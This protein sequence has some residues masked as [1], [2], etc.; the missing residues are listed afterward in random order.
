MP[1]LLLLSA[2][3]LLAAPEVA[4]RDDF[5][6][7]DAWAGNNAKA[8]ADIAGRDGQL[9]LTDPPG[10]EVTWGTSIARNIGRIDLGRFPW[11]VVSVPAMT[12]TFQVKMVNLTTKEKSEPLGQLTAPGLLLV[13]IPEATKWQGE[14]ELSLWCYVQGT[15]KSVTVDWVKVV[16]ALTAEEQQSRPRAV[17]LRE[18]LPHHGLTALASRNAWRPLE[19]FRH[20]AIWLSERVVYRDTATGNTV[21]RMTVDPG[22]DKVVYYDLPEWNADGSL[23]MFET[24]RGL[25]RTWVMH[26][27]GTG[28]RPLFGDA[29]ATYGAGYWSVQNPDVWYAQLRDESGTAVVAYDVRTGLAKPVVRTAR[30]DLSLMPPHPGEQHF[31]LAR[32]AGGDRPDCEVVILGV[33]GSE[34]VV[35]IGGRFHRLR[36]AKSPD[37]RVFYNRDDPRTQWVIL[38]DGSGRTEIPDPGSH[39]DWTWNGQY[40]TYFGAGG[41]YRNTADGQHRELVFAG[42]GGHGGPS[43]D[44][45]WFVGDQYGGAPFPFSIV[46]SPL[47]PGSVASQL[48]SHGSRPMSHDAPS[49]AH[50]DHHSTHP[51]PSFSPDG[52]KAVFSSY[53][54]RAYVDIHVA[55]ARYPDPVSD[56]TVK[57]AGR[58]VTLAWQP[59]ANHRELRGYAVYRAAASGVGYRQVNTTLSTQP[60]LTDTLP[61]DA[62]AYYV[63]VPV[64]HSGLAGLPSREVCAAADGAWAGTFRMAIEAES[65]ATDG[66]WRRVIDQS[67]QSGGVA[68]RL[69]RGEGTWQ[70][71]IETPRRGDAALWVRADGPGTVT[72]GGP[73]VDMPSGWHWT[74]VA[75]QDFAADVTLRFAGEGLVFDKL[76]VTNAGDEPSGW[77]FDTAPPEAPSGITARAVDSTGGEVTWQPSPAAAHYNV[78]AVASDEAYG[79]Q[80]SLV[81][82]P[83]EAIFRDWGQ[84]PG[85]KQHYRITA[86]DGFGQESAPSPAVQVTLPQGKLETVD[87]GAAEAGKVD[88][89]EAAADG[90]R[91]V[92]TVTA[93]TGQATWSVDIPEAGEYAIW[94]EHNVP[95]PESARRATLQI[96]DGPKLGYTLY[97]PFGKY[98]WWPASSNA[99]STPDRFAL[100][101]GQ[102]VLRLEVAGA[103]VKLAGLRLSNDPR[104]MP[105]A[106]SGEPQPTATEQT[107]ARLEPH[108]QVL[109][110]EPFANL[111]NWHHEGQGELR[112]DADEPSTL[113]LEIVGSKQG[114]EGS[115]AFCRTDFPD[116]IAL[117]YDLKV[118]TPNGLVIT[119]VAMQGLH[120]EDMIRDLPGRTGIFADYVGRDAK[121][122]SYH[123]SVSRYDDRGVHTGVSNWRRNPG[124]NLMA[125]G[126]DLCQEIGQWYRIRIVKDGPTVQLQV[127]GE[128]AHGFVDPQTLESP[129]PTAGKIGFRAIGSE[130]KALVRNLR[131]VALR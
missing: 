105:Q 124:L 21:W 101:A 131:V 120:G 81:A 73:P 38:P 108:G 49:S 48:A 40:L 71:R 85:T 36:F 13:N 84:V 89:M 122:K 18:P 31:L 60:G 7:V 128:V 62:P 34:Q 96:D 64:E 1:L 52:T 99:T 42:G 29:E 4:F 24:R 78:Y 70:A 41:V 26:A 118:L 88:G 109:Y 121:L 102:H 32:N 79:S 107:M 103:G 16:S 58:Q 44:G 23:L 50:P 114:A 30:R 69:D 104:L 116:H 55:I 130:V 33:D 94:T 76:L 125:Q 91:K 47:A 25:G 63:V 74:K 45:Q 93:K 113:R 54:D 106:F 119:F 61:D 53:S 115:M 46:T 35:P 98:A 3:P 126:P 111:D 56:L 28:L 87:L 59:P 67:R 80:A 10:G 82:S 17:K 100:T 11:L 15:E 110:E 68:Y 83:A 20:G 51:H 22:V 5:D 39:P 14:A 123:V 19:R 127:N 75:A 2:L 72:A 27:D 129:L 90:D 77:R 92:L 8:P 66:S 97:G 86:V 37:L 112:L 12:G 43:M 117:E 6:S 65:A 95:T 9:V 57:R